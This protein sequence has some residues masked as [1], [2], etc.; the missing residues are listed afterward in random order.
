MTDW[1]TRLLHPTASAPGGFRSLAV[2][3]YRG[4]TT[5]F[6]R[7]ADLEDNWR[8]LDHYTYGLFG[9]PTSRELALRVAELEGGGQTLLAPSGLGAIALV[10]FAFARSGAHALVPDNVYVP[11]RALGAD[12]ARRFGMRVDSYD[13]MRPAS[14]AERLCDETVLVWVETPGSVTM[15]VP[16]VGALAEAAHA[17]GAVVAVDNTYAAGVL[18]DAFAHGADVSMQALTKYVGGHSD[19]LLGAVTA[20]EDAYVQAL[21]HARDILGMAVSPDE[22]ALALRGL[23]TL[24]VRLAHLETAALAVAHWLA[25]R[26]EIDIVLHPALASCPGHANWVR[27]FQGSAS[28]FSVVFDARFGREEVE[29]FVD[30]LGLFGIGYS[31]GGTRSLALPQFQLGARTRDYGER[32]VRFNIG[33]EA[34]DDLIADLE[35]ALA[36]LG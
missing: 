31:W 15:E 33:L 36:S 6:E 30:A 34:V 23:Q 21:R 16:D 14:L 3:T 25:A 28:I 8:R 9:T 26:P 35:Q 20:R 7:A 2:P 1:R 11:N 18:F 13:P 10:W 24:G 12:L 32:L 27:D 22:C 17:R 29:R 19:L 5:L 4:S